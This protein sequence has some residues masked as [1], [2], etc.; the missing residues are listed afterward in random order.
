M[1]R[2]I[3]LLAVLL[4]ATATFLIGWNDGESVEYLP[5]EAALQGSSG[6]ESGAPSATAGGVLTGRAL[7][8]GSVPPPRKLVVDND[9]DHCQVAEDEVQ[10]IV[11]GEDKGLAGVVVE[12]Q[13]VKHEGE[14]EWKHPQDGYVIRQKGC[15]FDPRFLVIPNG[16]ELTIYNDD[17]VLHNVNTA[18][19]NIAQP[20]GQSYESKRK[21]TYQGRPFIKV[22]CN[23]HSWMQGWIYVARSPYYAVTGADGKFKIENVPPGSYKVTTRHPKLRTQRFK[24]TVAAGQTAEQEVTFKPRSK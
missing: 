10:E 22:S 23:V 9:T 18:Q 24:I 2:Q 14:W 15:R 12:I 17:P 7:F 8:E 16:A 4:A 21:I 6:P 11:V 3:P 13:G 1:T 5:T 19:W 20:G